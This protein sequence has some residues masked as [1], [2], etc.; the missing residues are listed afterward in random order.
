MELLPRQLSTSNWTASNNRVDSL[1]S[2]ASFVE[3]PVTYHA[4]RKIAWWKERKKD[5]M[6]SFKQESRYSGFFS[7][8]RGSSCD[9]SCKKKD[10][11]MERKI[12]WADSN[13]SRFSGFFSILCRSSCNLHYHAIFPTKKDCTMDQKNA[14]YLWVEWHVSLFQSSVLYCTILN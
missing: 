7:F 13:S 6:N 4:R 10:C 2:L 9:L 11:M 12:A 14:G 3:V 1:V 5:C 8:L